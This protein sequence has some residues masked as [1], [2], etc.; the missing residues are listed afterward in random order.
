MVRATR[1]SGFKVITKLFYSFPSFTPI[2][3]LYLRT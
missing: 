3:Q 1:L 2:S